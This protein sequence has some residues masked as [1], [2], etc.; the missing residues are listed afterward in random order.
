MNKDELELW[1]K[2]IQ[3]AARIKKWLVVY[4][5]VDS[6]TTVQLTE[7]QKQVFDQAIDLAKTSGKMQFCTTKDGERFT[8]NFKVVIKN[9]EWKDPIQLA[10]KIVFY[11][12]QRDFA[13]RRANGQTVTWKEYAESRKEEAQK[14]KAQLLE[15]IE[16]D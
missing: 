1:Q 14:I 2:E 4:D 3:R 6:S 7:R 8:T 15:V 12:Y 13:D 9:P 10:R 5:R 11:K 16:N